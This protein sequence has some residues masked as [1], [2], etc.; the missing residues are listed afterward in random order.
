MSKTK[1]NKKKVVSIR[2]NGDFFQKELHTF[3]LFSVNFFLMLFLF[4]FTSFQESNDSKDYSAFKVVLYH[5]V[6]IIV[7][8]ILFFFGS[9]T[10]LFDSFFDLTPI[11]SNIYSAVLAVIGLHIAL[12]Y[13]IYRAYWDKD[14]TSSSNEKED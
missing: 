4:T 9:K 13:Y 10:I 3:L 5:C 1:N 8:P 12:G 2:S 6:L 14:T 7:T 11:K